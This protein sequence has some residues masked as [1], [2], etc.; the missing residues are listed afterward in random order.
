MNNITVI[1]PLH[2]FNSDVETYLTSAIESVIN[3][4]I[5]ST[6]IL[7][8]I[9]EEF[10]Q[11][12]STFIKKYKKTQQFKVVINT[13]SENIQSQLNCGVKHVDTK[14]FSYLEF[15]DSFSDFWLEVATKYLNEDE[16][17][18]YL[19]IVKQYNEHNNFIGFRNE[20]LWASSFSEELG[21][22][23]LGVLET[24]P[25][26]VMSGMVMKVENFLKLGGLKEELKIYFWYDFLLRNVSSQTANDNDMRVY[27]IPKFGY[28]HTVNRPNS[29]DVKLAE[30]LTIEEHEMWLKK[31]K[32]SSEC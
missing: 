11:E 1:I 19:P 6:K 5:K 30:T 17:T 12:I 18:T 21:Y 16:N 13:D 14:F 10:K 20:E 25:F 22:H 32:M 7:L 23:D 8:V 26:F 2:E 24:N 29:Y 9:R 3:Q 28:N 15:D 4:T 27:V 31:I